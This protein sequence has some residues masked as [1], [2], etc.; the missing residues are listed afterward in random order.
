MRG[1]AMTPMEATRYAPPD[2]RDP[3]VPATLSD[4]ALTLTNLREWAVG[5]HRRSFE[6]FWSDNIPPE[7][8]A[9]HG[10]RLL[11]LL[12]VL[13]ILDGKT[14]PMRSLPP[15]IASPRA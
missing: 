13:D 2:P 6:V 10:A 3:L 5:A 11:T 8:I 7:T 1:A 4:F 9:F 14:P 15:G 12:D